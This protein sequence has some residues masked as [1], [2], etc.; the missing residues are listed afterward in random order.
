MNSLSSI[1]TVN[2]VTE[3][4]QQEKQIAAETVEAAGW[5]IK[6][7]VAERFNKLSKV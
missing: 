2:N 6:L 4:A 5:I 7:F 1:F 3:Q